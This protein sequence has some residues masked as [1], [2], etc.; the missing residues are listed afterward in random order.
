MEEYTNSMQAA[1]MMPIFPNEISIKWRRE[2]TI[3]LRHYQALS[4]QFYM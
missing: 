2:K 4:I 1:I 3:K